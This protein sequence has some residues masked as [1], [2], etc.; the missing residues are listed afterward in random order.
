[1]RRIEAKSAA[2][3]PGDTAPSPPKHLTGMEIPP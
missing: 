3:S 2:T 1:V